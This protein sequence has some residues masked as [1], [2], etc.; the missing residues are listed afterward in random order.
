[1]ETLFSPSGS[2]ARGPQNAALSLSQRGC[3]PPA[4]TGTVPQGHQN[5]ASPAPLQQRDHKVLLIDAVP[6]SGWLDAQD[7]RR[8]H[9]DQHQNKLVQSVASRCAKQK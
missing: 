1:M 7:P 5:G 4:W 9:S 6:Q 8:H 2:A 3:Q